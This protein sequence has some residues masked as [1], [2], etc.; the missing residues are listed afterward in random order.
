[1]KARTGPNARF[2]YS[3]CEMG[4]DGVV[5]NYDSCGGL[6][7]LRCMSVVMS[8]WLRRSMI[9]SCDDEGSLSM[10]WVLW[11]GDDASLNVRCDVDESSVF[12]DIQLCR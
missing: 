10:K 4:F 2:C 9:S 5:A 8:I 3:I 6:M 1:M 11:P 12:D 7:M